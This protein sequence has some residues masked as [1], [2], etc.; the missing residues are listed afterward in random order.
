MSHDMT[1]KVA[2]ITGAAGAI[3]FA[4]ATLLAARGAKIA[5][6]DIK[7]ADFA[8]LRAEIPD[9]DCLLVLEGDVSD[10]ASYAAVVAK[11][12]ATY[13]KIDI[14]FNNAGIEGPSAQ[15]P[16]FPLDGFRRVIEVNVVGVFLG[17][18]LVIPLM[19]KAGSGSIINS[20]SVAGMTGSPGLCGYV[21]SKHAVLGLTRA[22]AVE[23][24]G[25]GVRVNCIN[26]GPIDSRMMTSIE[27]GLGAKAD[28][29]HDAFAATIPMKRYGTPAEVA[30]LVAFL[31]SDDAGYVNGGAYTVDGGLTAG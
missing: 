13:G 12:V 28:E 1:G 26:P 18:K 17:L 16:D 30:G 21:A 7:G 6:M 20:S 9:Q 11:T 14:F 23:C 27:K 8:P 10:E 4:A 5:A 22:A 31:A 19:I 3:G 15:I 29:V 25:K 2:L 24:G